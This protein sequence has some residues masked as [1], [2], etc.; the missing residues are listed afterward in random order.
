[1][2]HDENF[3][4]GEPWLNDWLSWLVAALLWAGVGIALHVVLG[5]V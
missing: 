3:R 2:E 1:M 5:R 4:D